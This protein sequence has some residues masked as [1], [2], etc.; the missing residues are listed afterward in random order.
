MHVSNYLNSGVIVMNLD[1]W[2]KHD[3]QN[4][5]LTY[6]LDNRDRIIYPD[7]DALN[8]I[9]KDTRMEL[10]IIYNVAHYLFYKNIDN[11]PGDRYAEIKEARESPVIFH[12]M[13]PTKPWSLGNYIP[14]NELFL[15]YQEL[16]GWRYVVIQKHFFKRLVYTLFPFYRKKAWE[17]KTY[18]DGWEKYYK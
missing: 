17:D 3:I 16:A 8:V 12:Y 4:K 18:V 14:G 1:Y 13:G 5:V 6:I 15:K 7:Q 2:R 10:P 9:L 11:I